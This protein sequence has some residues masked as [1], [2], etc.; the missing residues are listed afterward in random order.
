MGEPIL[1][2]TNGG[3][4]FWIGNGHGATGAYRAIPENT[5]S[6][7]SEIVRHREGIEL[8]LRNIVEHPDE[9]ISILPKKFFLMWA[10]DWFNIN[11]TIMPESYHGILPILQEIAQ[12][13]WM[14]I[15]I[16]ATLGVVTRPIK[17]Y[18]LRSP[19]LI[20]PLTLLYWAAFHMMFFGSPRFHMQ[21][22]PLIA[23]V[24]VHSLSDDRDWKAW[25][26]SGLT[27]NSDP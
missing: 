18:W 25:L 6:S 12:G 16:A 24:A 21:V 10:S 15:V 3:T 8:G 2:A 26:P 4:N 7:S 22:I 17:R 19:A 11:H 27:R 9:W 13:Y 5:F 23:I 14:G 1:T 20:L